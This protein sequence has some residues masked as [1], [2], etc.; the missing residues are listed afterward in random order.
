[1]AEG[2]LPL[3]PILDAYN[4]ALEEWDHRKE[5]DLSTY[6]PKSELPFGL[7]TH[8]NQRR[9]TQPWFY[10]LVEDVYSIATLDSFAA[11]KS[12]RGKSDCIEGNERG[13]ARRVPAV[14]SKPEPL[15]HLRP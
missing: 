15:L 12:D 14:S 3:Q 7:M 6:W 8:L 10:A 2:S 4:T 13:C 9:S 5:R 1:M 11:A